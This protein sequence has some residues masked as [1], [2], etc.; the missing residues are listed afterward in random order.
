VIPTHP[1]TQ[2]DS[3]PKTATKPAKG[4]SKPQGKFDDS[5]RGVLFTNDKDG[6]EARPDYTGNLAI[7]PDDY[8]VDGDGLIR[9]RLAAWLKESK[10][11]DPYLSISASQPKKA[12]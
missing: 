5:N 7:N 3:V 10:A 11:G 12:D 6:N 8:E 9:V 2:E 4:S 1:F